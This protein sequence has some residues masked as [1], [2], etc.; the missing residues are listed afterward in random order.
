MGLYSS[1]GVGFELQ[2]HCFLAGIRMYSNGG[3]AYYGW[4]KSISKLKSER[5]VLIMWL[6]TGV[7]V[8]LR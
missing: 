3:F 8:T 1:R 5:T 4:V 6:I 2:T 7:M